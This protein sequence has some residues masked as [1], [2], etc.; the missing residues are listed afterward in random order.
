MTRTTLK[1]TLT[2]AVLVTTIH[3]AVPALERGGIPTKIDDGNGN[4]IDQL[5][6][7]DVVVAILPK[8]DL[9]S[10]ASGLQIV[11]S[12]AD[13]L[14]GKKIDVVILED[15]AF[16]VN[17]CLGIKATVGS[18]EMRFERPEVHFGL[19]GARFTFRINSVDLEVLKLKMKP[20]VPTLTNRDPC[21][22]SSSFEVGGSASDIKVEAWFKPKLILDECPR[23]SLADF[24]FSVSIGG[25]NLKPLQNNLDAV[26]K[27]LIEASLKVAVGDFVPDILR[28]SFN[29]VI[30]EHFCQGRYLLYQAYMASL[31][32]GVN[33][34]H[35][36]DVYVAELQSRFPNVDLRDVRFGYSSNQPPN[37]AT[38]DCHNMYFNDAAYVGRL[39]NAQLSD[40]NEWD[41]L[42]H[43]LR[44]TE[45]CSEVGGRKPYGEMW[46]NDLA[47]SLLIT[48][49]SAPSATMDDLHDNMPMEDDANARS[50]RT[51][52]VTGLVHEAGSGDQLVGA[53]LLAYAA[54]GSSSE[55]VASATVRADGFELFLKSGTWDLRVRRAGETASVLVKEAFE[56]EADTDGNGLPDV[57][58]FDLPVGE[59][60]GFAEE[61]FRRGDVDDSAEID[62][63]DALATLSWLF[64][65][66][67]APRCEKAADVNDDGAV[68][69]S[70]PLA[71]LTFLF[72]GGDEPAAPY[73]S[74]GT[75]PTADTLRCGM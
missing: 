52:V 31:S 29:D 56:V 68:D 57:V 19:D 34:H 32:S 72:L 16:T 44:H 62:I 45:Q 2:A 9:S 24:G 18:F 22:W 26:A 55:P 20:R 8:V 73:S 70:D 23:V 39:R 10:V 4:L 11:E 58:Y 67:R 6:L 69:V 46:F 53:E 25:L 75:D 60:S 66:G 74:E 15:K 7:D 42:L 12:A 43:E 64:T 21:D 27:E 61:Q 54:D 1:T 5:D 59:T 38:T 13:G 3:V 48:G 51:T 35:L 47:I 40:D 65:G 28:T 71:L 14:A 36:P 49:L 50:R 17:S 33:L 37:N 41:W 63:T 30:A